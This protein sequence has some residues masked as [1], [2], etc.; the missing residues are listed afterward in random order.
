MEDQMKK[1]MLLLVLLS[2][3]VFIPAGA[4]ADNPKDSEEDSV[5][6]SKLVSG[7][8]MRGI[9]PALMSGR[10]GDIA[11][12]PVKRSTW[13][14]AVCSGNVWKTTNA[15]TT[16]EPIFD[17]YGTYSIGC[18]T[19]DPNNRHVIW[20]GTGENNSQRSVGYG[21]G[22]YKSVDGGKKFEKVGLDNSEHIG[23]ILI[24]PRNSDVVYIAAQGP[25]WSA[26]G[27]RGLY[28][29]TDGGKTWNLILDISENTGVTDIHF[30]PR[31]PDVVYAAAYQRRR[32]V[33]T[34]I[35]GGPESGIHKSTDAGATWKE[36]NKGLPGGDK[37]RIGLAVSPMQPD[38]LYAIVEA[39]NEGSGFYRSEDGGEN[40]KKM[41]DY[42]SGSPQYYQE[43]YADPH[44]FDRVYSLDTYLM[45][46]DDGGKTF[47]RLGQKWK[48]VDE[49]AIA[50]DPEDPDH[51][52]TGCDGGLYET[53]DRGKTFHYKANLPITQFYKCAVDNDFPFY[54]VYGGTQDNATQGGPSRTRTVHGIRNSDWFITV[55]GD[56]FDPA[57]DPEDPNI[58]YSQWQYGGLI[59]FDKRSGERIDIKP[60]EDIDG[61]PLRWNWDSALMISPHLNTRLYY[62]S[63]IL[64]RS[65]DRGDSW[66]AVSPDLTRNLDR[67]KLEVM[68]RVW[69][70]DAV[71]KNNSTSFYGTIVSVS[72]SPLQEGLL[73]AGTDD[74]LIQ[75]SEDGGGNWTKYERFANVPE[76][77][78]VSD[79]EASLHDDNIVYAALD[80][81]K[82][83][84]FKPYIVRSSNRG[85]SWE[86]I[87][88]NLPE[89]GTVYTIAQDH[90]KENLLFAGTEFGVFFTIDEGKEWIQLKEGI[91]TIIIR[92]LEIQRRENDL[93]AASFGRGFYILDDYTPLRYITEEMLEKEAFMFP[94]RKA[95]MYIQTNPMAGREKAYQGAAFFTAP[96]PP[97]GATFTYYLKNTLKT[98]K[99]LR[100]EK[101]KELAKEGGDVFYPTW[102]ALKQE[103]RE[104]KPSIFL[105]VRDEEGNVVRRIEGKTS[106]GIHR[107]TWDFRYPGFAPAKIEEDGFGPLAVP[108]TYNVSIDKMDGGLMTQIVAPV[109]FE[110]EPLG[111]SS[112]SEVDRGEIL[113]FQKKTG[114]LQRAVMG[115]NAAAGE[116]ANRITYIKN[117]IEKTPALQLQLREDARSL[118]LRLMDLR[119]RI[120]GDPT[121]RRRSEPSMR[122]I[123]SRINQIVWGHWASTSPPTQTHRKNYDIAAEEFGNILGDL[124]QLIEDDLIALEDKLEEAGAP[125]TPGRGVPKWER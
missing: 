118:E 115:A 114:E 50:F 64:F 100:Q 104:E 95:W 37:G 89:K 92:D 51:L 46:T 99:T 106:Q 74:G 109:D 88:G 43:I 102:D 20:V 45:V 70:V 9:G 81:H 26:G 35:D 2:I 97:F 42:L 107:A 69:S 15:G 117:V 111:M 103:D 123:M 79:I 13:Y 16:W 85:R 24:D 93:V 72:E 68:D 5:L 121:K 73:F 47:S 76:Y 119:E 14:I 54:N 8:S 38:V 3:A 65:D 63:Q 60:Q 25:L 57:V 10:V 36:I 61:P 87:S 125:W 62:G 29:T 96:N 90:V 78:Y 80:N 34:L 120:T 21:D 55:F 1:V 11:V 4:T 124:R 75:V 67:N 77:S 56:G 28:K 6:D 33:W 53:W 71:A 108:G 105:T 44:V 48:H 101:E 17:S 122:G 82:K 59:R 31:N 27:D 83:G 84:D 86:L 7:L 49:H 94:I 18:V 58:V 112:L 12:D 23:K 110:V 22:V 40:W 98:D 91:P 52:I 41:S 66:Q 32:H 30:D 39:A 19:I 116:A 113:A